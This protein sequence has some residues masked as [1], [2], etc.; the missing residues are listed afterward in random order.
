MISLTRTLHNLT[1]EDAIVYA[2][3]SKNL[4]AAGIMHACD[5]PIKDC[6]YIMKALNSFKSILIVCHALEVF[7]VIAIDSILT[8]CVYYD[9]H[10]RSIRRVCT[11]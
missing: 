11:L 3:V 4:T 6:S 8:F 9:I 7:C 1:Y 5:S 2:T 10:Y